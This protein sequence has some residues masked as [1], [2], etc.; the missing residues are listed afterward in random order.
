MRNAWAVVVAVCI[1]LVAALAMADRTSVTYA[2]TDGGSAQVPTL[3]ARNALE[4]FN[5]YAVAICVAA[6]TTA[7]PSAP[8]RPIVPGGSMSIDVGDSH[9]YAFRLCSGT[10]VASCMGDGGVVVTEIQ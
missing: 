6:G 4:L 9:K 5:S 2:P 7:A 1:G 8:C 3:S 10:T